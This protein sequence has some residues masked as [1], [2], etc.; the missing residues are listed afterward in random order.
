MGTWKR[1][2][3]EG[4]LTA[5]VKWSSLGF[6]GRLANRDLYWGVVHHKGSSTVPYSWGCLV[7]P[8]GTKHSNDNV[9]LIGK[10]GLSL[11]WL[12]SPT[13]WQGCSWKV[14]PLISETGCDSLPSLKAELKTLILIEDPF[15]K[16]L[17]IK[18]YVCRSIHYRYL[19]PM[20]ARCSSA[21]EVY[22]RSQ[23]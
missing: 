3:Y 1:L 10:P 18:T 7:N 16:P 22:S 19:N 21:G 13:F 15:S 11:I 23:I 12:P 5:D 9:P 2:Q 4:K 14:L 6:S 8:K 17:P 20:R